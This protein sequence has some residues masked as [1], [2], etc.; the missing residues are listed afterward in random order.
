V[1]QSGG[2]QGI[3]LAVPSNLARRVLDDIVRYGSVRRGSI[4]SIR[5]VNITGN[6]AAELG[7]RTTKGALVWSI[8]RASAAFE[9]GIRPGDVIVAL[10]GQSVDDAAHFLRLL[11]DAPIGSTITLRLVRRGAEIDAK[12]QVSGATTRRAAI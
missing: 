4:G 8:A 3:G 9:A 7:L 11:S 5:T 2:Y 10:D 6:L 12:V 1:S